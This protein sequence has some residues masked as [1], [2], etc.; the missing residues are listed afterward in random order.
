MQYVPGT[1]VTF[2]G[3]SRDLKAQLEG[4]ASDDQGDVVVSE[5][6]ET[7]WMKTSAL[8]RK[9]RKGLG[10]KEAK[11]GKAADEEEVRN[12]LRSASRLG[13]SARSTLT[14]P[15]TAL[16]TL[17]LASISHRPLSSQNKRVWD[18]TTEVA[19][20]VELEGGGRERVYM[21]DNIETIVKR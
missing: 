4:S 15:L 8:Q 14:L 7:V 21:E 9:V 1:K 17:L 10:L 20:Y 19:K 11:N 12:E 6:I 2:N 13:R 5:M 18:V 16:N 3:Y